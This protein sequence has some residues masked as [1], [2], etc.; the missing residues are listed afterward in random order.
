MNTGAW[1][2]TVH[3][4]AK[5]QDT[6]ERVSAAQLVT[7]DPQ[8]GKAVLSVT[9]VSAPTTS[10]SNKGGGAQK[11]ISSVHLGGLSCQGF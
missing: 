11:S 2:A 3:G 5:S 7:S 9:G 8:L 4:V 10:S 6:T 1:G